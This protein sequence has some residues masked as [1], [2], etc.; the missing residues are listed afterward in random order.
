MYVSGV[1]QIDAN[2]RVRSYL[3]VA[4][5]QHQ[6]KTPDLLWA[7]SAEDLYSK[8]HT[9]LV[10]TYNHLAREF[11]LAGLTVQDLTLISDSPLVPSIAIN[12]PC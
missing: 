7:V 10:S 1:R 4:S 3:R 12:Q 8:I 5:Y 9:I 2:N 6:K 11:S